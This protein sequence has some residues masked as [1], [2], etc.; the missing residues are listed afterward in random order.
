MTTYIPSVAS[1]QDDTHD[2]DPVWN[3]EIEFCELISHSEGT[4]YFFLA[5]FYLYITFF[6]LEH[7]QSN[8]NNFDDIMT[9]LSD[10]K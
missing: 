1:S 5:Y 6:Y 10:G 2:I 8:Q 9:H 3:T 7:P 4:S